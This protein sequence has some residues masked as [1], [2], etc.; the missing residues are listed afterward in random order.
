MPPSSSRD[1]AAQFHAANE[2]R[3]YSIYTRSMDA[4]LEA[5]ARSLF[6]HFLLEEGNVVVDA[7]SG[8]GALAERVAR[9]FRGVRVFALDIS[10]ELLERAEVSRSLVTLVFGN[11]AA[12]QFPNSSVHLKYFST[13]G[14][15]IESFGGAGAMTR[16][17]L[18]S[19][20]ELV[21]GGRLVIRD[22]AKPEPGA[23][24]LQILSTVGQ[25]APPGAD[26][27]SIDYNLLSTAALFGRFHSEFRGGNAF[28]SV[29][30]TV[31]GLPA[32]RL[33]AEWAHEF[34]LRKD[35]TGNWRQE[36]KEKYTY[37]TLAEAR[38]VLRA[39]GFINV[40]VLPD[41]NEYI[42]K[43]RLEGKVALFREEGDQLVPL[44]FPPSH[45][46]A[47]GDKPKTLA[48][49]RKTFVPPE[50]GADDDR[51]LSSITVETT[52]QTVRIGERA[53]PVLL[54]S[55]RGTKKEVFTLRNGN[56]LLKV[57]RRDAASP[58]SACKSI[59]QI[60]ERQTVLDAYGVAHCRVLDADPDGPPFRYVVQERAP[61][62]AVSAADL[63]R[64][65]TL[66]A[67]DVHAM[68]SV[69]NRFERGKEWQ[70]DTNP[71][72]WFRVSAAHR[73]FFLYVS[74]K[75]YRYD[76]RWEFRRIGL[77]QWIDPRFVEA[78]VDFAA[79][80]PTER[81]YRAFLPRWEQGSEEQIRWWKRALDPSVAPG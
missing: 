30:R 64:S 4:A 28:A 15:E 26:P 24:V 6:P 7:G 72:S 3:D 70:L 19:F 55:L 57:V 63:I 78:A 45:M 54:P 67:A 31:H 79:A 33:D 41:P 42:L 27:S 69:V 44:P 71:F 23:V 73:P 39:A 9:E 12:Q 2:D 65:Q 53:F 13:S 59:F 8:T 17:V 16:A 62:T 36:I 11:A 76:E 58:H 21:P 46:I 50:R 48:G 10:H 74:G 1:L 56:A 18:A 81:D 25:E 32:V 52:T 20:R 40:R 34:C 66:T 60:V 43:N 37:W 68:A 22:F 35:Y 61:R 80:L 5:K 29:P 14:H 49:A 47:V 51:I 38:R 77:L 75:V